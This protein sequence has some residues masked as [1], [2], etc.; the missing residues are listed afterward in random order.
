M[1]YKVY[2]A[3]N[4]TFGFGDKP[5]FPEAYDKVATVECKGI[6][7]VF[8]ATNH[9]D[10]NWMT[11]PEV[12]ERAKCDCRSTSVGDVVVDED[13]NKM[14]CAMVGWENMA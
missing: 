12:I 3:K 11:N 9:I 1:K 7:D 6:E 2:H 13:G 10:S 4:P 14:Y 5:A 8:R